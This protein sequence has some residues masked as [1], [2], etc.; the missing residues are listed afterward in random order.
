M[1]T[2][3]AIN[4]DVDMSLSGLSE[5]KRRRFVLFE[6]VYDLPRPIGHEHRIAITSMR[7]GMS[8]MPMPRVRVVNDQMGAS[9]RDFPELRFIRFDVEIASK[10]K[11]DDQPCLP[12]TMHSADLLARRMPMV[13]RTVRATLDSSRVVIRV[14]ATMGP[15]ITS[16]IGRKACKDGVAVQPLPPIDLKIH[17]AFRVAIDTKLAPKLLEDDKNND[18]RSKRSEVAA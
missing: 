3:Y 1:T 4:R 10:R 14:V 11:Q 18:N 2:Q 15:P 5:R 8:H 17:V 9:V 6:E 7:G 13:P 16:N 12:Y